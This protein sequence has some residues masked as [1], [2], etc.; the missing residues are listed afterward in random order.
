MTPSIS[1]ILKRG[2][3]TGNN[4]LES[5]RLEAER[6]CRCS[7]ERPFAEIFLNSKSIIDILDDKI[8]GVFGHIMINFSQKIA[9]MLTTLKK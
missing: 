4:V 3:A 6:A 2:F 9:S 8:K 5:P 1:T 7:G